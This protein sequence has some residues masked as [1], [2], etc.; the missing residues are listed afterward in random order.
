MFHY[1][2]THR[3]VV[4]EACRSCI[5]PN[6]RSQEWHLR[7]K[8]HYLKGKSL[9]T[10]VEQLGGYSLRSVLELKVRQPLPEDRCT[11]IPY[12]EKYSGF[13]CL[14]PGC[15]YYTVRLRTMKDHQTS[16]HQLQPAS[17]KKSPLWEEC[18]LQ[19]YF[20]AK[21]SIRYFRVYESE[22]VKEEVDE[23]AEEK[24]QALF[25]KLEEDLVQ[26]KQDLEDQAGVVHD[27]GDAKSAQVPWLDKTNFPFYLT[28]LTDVEIQSSFRLPSKK[29]ME[30]PEQNEAD[31]RL[32][33]ILLA[34]EAMLRDAYALC[35][36][37][38]PDRK[39]T[40]QRANILS[41]FYVGASGKSKGFRYTKLPSSLVDYFRLIK[42][43]LVYY[44][45]V[46][47]LPQQALGLEPE[48]PRSPV[49]DH[50][51][52]IPDRKHFHSTVPDGTTPED[53]IV[54]S[55]LQIDSMDEIVAALDLIDEGIQE[56]ELKR[57]I[58]QFYIALICHTVG[59]QPFKS[60]VIS[61]C[62]MI[63]RE[64]PKD[65]KGKWK[66]PANFNSHLSQLTWTAQLVIF[67]YAC[68]MQQDHENQIPAFLSNLCTKFL[69]QLVET[70][71]GF[72]LQWRLY[73]FQVGKKTLTKRQARWSMDGFMVEYNG[74]EL[75]IK[76]ITQLV[77]SEFRQAS[78]LLWDELMFG[79]TDL[80]SLEAW[81]L[82]DDLDSEDYGGSWLSH[83]LNQDL[84]KDSDRA[85][86][87]QIQRRPKLQATFLLEADEGGFKLCPAAMRLYED[88]VQEFLSRLL[89][90]FHVPPAPPLRAPEMLSLTWCNTGR[91]RHIF[92][93]E[94]SVMIYT[95]YH[96]SQNQTG[97]YKDNIRFLPKAI[98]E[99][100]L[101]Y[102]AYVL[103]LRQLFLR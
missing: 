44:W 98:G 103:L 10:T 68:F 64:L 60:P 13:T 52:D 26:V 4:C 37:S 16:V 14:F 83:P 89:I 81:R 51:G 11:V 57:T 69:Q 19:T 5:V 85:L 25:V 34:A 28:G 18:L 48:S 55:Q 88:R 76:D 38:S 90:L 61:F 12:L 24:K 77:V 86:M 53:T 41:Q 8:P 35:S 33:R 47:Y 54:P 84:V 42:Q 36:N 66:H 82:K 101:A 3:V 50:T 93:W 96:K 72:I 99:L 79:T 75:H 45:R 23:E 62:A 71:F 80:P 20:T 40:Q 100:L 49:P 73:L 1:N 17:H 31:V 27:L 43:L 87:L 22:E 91:P 95:Q 39:M 15:Q 67:D 30:L 97:A 21:G 58:R 92:L 46:V 56:Q 78:V 70:P 74:T 63:S 7:K 94:K 32:V 6:S 2:P 65:Q 59:S 9:K 102:I 29:E